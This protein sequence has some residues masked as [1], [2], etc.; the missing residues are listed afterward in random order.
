MKLK[1]LSLQQ[2][3]RHDDAAEFEALFR[4]YYAP[5]CHYALK[6]VQD[7]DVAEEIV[8]EFFYQYWKNRKTISI[9]FSLKAYF[10]RS[11][12]NNALKHL[13]KQPLFVQDAQTLSEKESQQAE[14]SLG[15]FEAKELLILVDKILDEL[16]PRCSQIFR[17]SRFEGLK[18]QEIAQAL[19]IS[20]K[21]VEAN[22]GKALEVFRKKLKPYHQLTII[23]FLFV[24]IFY[25]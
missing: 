1:E 19:Q 12:H 3:I 25:A 17:M 14:N 15:D 16:P 6:I 18:Y 9:K 22:M 10:Y 21:T 11:I 13:R 23:L 4:T 5:L 20:V 2:K 24:S 7:Q 8:Q